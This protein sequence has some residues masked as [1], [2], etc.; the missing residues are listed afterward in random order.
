M[1]H[2]T[3]NDPLKVYREA[4]VELTKK[5]ALAAVANKVKRFIF[6]SS[7]LVNDGNFGSTPLLETDIPSPQTPYGISKLEAEEILREISAQYGLEVVI[8]RP[9][10]VYGPHVKG[11]FLSLLRL[12][13]VGLPFLP[14][15]ALNNK[16]SFV[17][18]NNLVDLLIAC[19]EHPKASNEVFFVSDD[20]D[21]SVTNLIKLL[22]KHLDKPRPLLPISV[23]LLEKIGKLLGKLDSVKKL[24]MPLQVNITK[25]KN[26]LGWRPVQEL[27]DGLQEMVDWFRE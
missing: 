3:E 18:V 24:S 14:L 27:S 7:L 1:V 13:N 2:E 8:I 9:P 4:N 17:S 6:I 21:V 10:L 25:V 20:E 26:L 16:R 19:I 11:N 23:G 5:L 15:G 22:A 12:V